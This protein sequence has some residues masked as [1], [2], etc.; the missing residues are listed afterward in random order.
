MIDILLCQLI[1]RMT[2]QLYYAD[3]AIEL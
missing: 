3:N 2:S 1:M